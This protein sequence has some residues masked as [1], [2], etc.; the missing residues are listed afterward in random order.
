MNRLVPSRAT[1]ASR[2]WWGMAALVAAA[3]LAATLLSYSVKLTALEVSPLVLVLGIASAMLA[4]FGRSLWPA[5]L[6]GDAIGHVVMHDRSAALV[7]VTATI[8]ALLAIACAT[9]LQRTSC[10]I[11]DLGQSLRFVGIAIV[12]SLAGGGL[13]GAV[14]VALHDVPPEYSA[15]EVVAWMVVGYLAGFVVGGGFVL[16]WGDPDVPLRASF[17]QPVAMA[18]FVAVACAAG[19]AFLAE[20]GPLIPLAMVGAIAIAGRAGARWGTAGILAIALIVAEAAHRGDQPPF[21]GLTPSGQ[22]ANAMLALSLFAAAIILLA[23]YREAG[24]GRAR[25]PVAIAIIFGGLMLVAGVTALA[26]NEVALNRD[27]PYVLSGLLS[28]GAAIGLG[29]LRMSRAPVRPPTARGLLL[30]AVAGG[31]YVVNLA[32]YLESVPLVGSGPAT[33]LTMTAPLWVVAIGVI[34]YRSRPTPGVVIGIVLIL[35]GAIA[36]ASGA[37]GSPAGVVLALASAA[38]FAGSVIITKRAL[39]HAN[40]IDV[41][42]A[43]STAAA[44]VALAVGAVVE[45]VEAFDLTAA[46]YGA[47]ALAALG[48]QLVP[49][50]GRSWALSHISADVVGAE[51]VLAPVTTTLLSFWL[52]DAV[53]TGGDV[54]GLALITTGAVVAALIG[55]RRPAPE[56]AGG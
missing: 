34:V 56:P 4:R 50:L 46:Q 19:A 30:A 47:L 39:D 8:H 49:T 29:V 28:L 51:G 44:V 42:L 55:S 54:I 48:A 16:A 11:R 40:V 3:A 41:A 21:G 38:V 6:V 15:G 13:T 7:A 26:A 32:L 25:A 2:A 10:W 35:G 12:I 23:G 36:I 31:V 22:A 37:M 14:F 17:R 18:A 1:L 20:I 24:E 33:G 27:T 9:W 45:G 43:A 53:T 5:V 52:L